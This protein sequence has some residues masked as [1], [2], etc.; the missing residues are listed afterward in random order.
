MPAPAA[1]PKAHRSSSGSSSGSHHRPLFGENY[2]DVTKD[3]SL[4]KKLGTGNFAKVLLG[5]CRRDLAVHKLKAG[6][7]VAI[8]VVKK[9][10]SR[11]AAIAKAH[12][13]MLRAE[14]EI[15]R[16]VS[17]PNIVQASRPSRFACPSARVRAPE[18]SRLWVQRSSST[19]ARA[20]SQYLS[21]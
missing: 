15:L 12:V 11:T 10:S 6:E 3:Y 21:A 19:A 13:Q 14:V 2:T 1:A 4:G 5:A 17:H 9:P 16:S 7:H 20:C 18:D 8:K